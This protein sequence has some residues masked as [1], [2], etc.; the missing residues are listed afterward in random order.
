MTSSITAVCSGEGFDEEALSQIEICVAEALTNVVKHAYGSEK[1]QIETRMAVSEG[2]VILEIVDHGKSIPTGVLED[3]P[4][5]M[6]FDPDLR[7]EL[8]EGGMGLVLLKQVMD[9]V[10]YEAGEKS[11]TLRLVYRRRK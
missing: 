8:P 5:T 2:S 4:S 9:E 7:S 11:N 10:S 6:Q 3:T 1:G